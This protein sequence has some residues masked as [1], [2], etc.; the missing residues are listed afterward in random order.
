MIWAKQV[1]PN[2]HKKIARRLQSEQLEPRRLLAAQA[3][4][5]SDLATATIVAFGQPVADALTSSNDHDVHRIEIAETGR[6]LAQVTSDDANDLETHPMLTLFDATGRSLLAGESTPSETVI[7]VY[8]T[9][10]IYHL[11]VTPASGSNGGDY[12]FSP[13]FT[14]T[15]S[16]FDP[17]TLSGRDPHAIAAGD[18]NRDGSV[19]LAIA[20]RDPNRNNVSILTGLGDGS[21]SESTLD[22]DGEPTSV[23]IGDFTG[24]GL[25]D[26]VVSVSAGISSTNRLVLFAGQDNGSWQLADELPLSGEPAELA[27]GDFNNDGA[28]ELAVTLPSLEQLAL[29]AFDNQNSIFPLDAFD[30]PGIGDAIQAADVNDD[31]LMDLIV[32]DQDHNELEFFRQTPFRTFAPRT[33]TLPPVSNPLAR[34][35]GITTGDIDHDGDTD[36]VVAYA[37]IDTVTIVVGVNGDFVAGSTVELTSGATSTVAAE[38]SRNRIALE[39]MDQDSHLD[40]V[41]VRP[42]ASTGF[43]AIARGDGTGEFQ[44][45]DRYAISGNPRD[46]LVADVDG[47]QRPDVIT[48]GGFRGGVSVLLGL[49]DGHLR[50]DANPDVGDSPFDLVTADLNRDGQMDLVTA[51]SLSDGLS[52]LLGTGN[53]AVWS[54][55]DIDAANTTNGVVAADFNRDGRIDLAAANLVPDESSGTNSVSLLLARGDG[56]FQSTFPLPVEHGTDKLIATDINQDGAVD[57]VATNRTA[58]SQASLTVLLG[59]PNAGASTNLADSFTTELILPGVASPVAVAAA[60]VNGDGHLDLVSAGERGDVALYLSAGRPLVAP[61]DAAGPRIPNAELLRRIVGTASDLAVVDL[62]DDG[63]PELAVTDLD[64][65][66]LKIIDVIARE[67]TAAFAVGNG[68]SRVIAAELNQQ[69]GVDLAVSNGG[70]NDISLLHAD[71]TGHLTAGTTVPTNSNPQGLVSGDFNQDGLMDLATA[72][73]LDD[74]ITLL[75]GTGQGQFESADQRGDS[76][77]RAEPMF[78]DFNG[79]SVQDVAV[80]NLSGEILLRLGRAGE[81][82]VFDPPVVINTDRPTRAI[83]V[84]HQQGMDKLVAIDRAGS[85]TVIYELGNNGSVIGVAELESS[86]PR[87]AQLVTGDVTGDGLNDLV[88]ANIDGTVDLFSGRAMA[89]MDPNPRTFDCGVN[90]SSLS[91]IDANDDGRLDI[92]LTDQAAG[93]VTLLRNDGE[94]IFSVLEAQRVSSGRLLVDSSAEAFNSLQS[95]DVTADA[96]WGDYDNDSH[97]DMVAVHAGANNATLQLGQGDGSFVRMADTMIATGSRPI[98]V[99][100]GQLNDDTGDGVIDDQDHLDMVVLNKASADVGVWLGDGAGH[101]NLLTRIDGGNRPSGLTIHDADDDGLVDLVLGNEFGDI[102]VLKHNSLDD[103]AVGGDLFQTF[104]RAGRDVQLS[105]GDVDGGGI[106]DWI[107]INATADG[108]AFQ[109]GEEFAGDKSTLRPMAGVVAPTA[110]AMADLN[111]DGVQDLVVT[112]GGANN[113]LVYLGLPTA[114]DDEPRAAAATGDGAAPFADPLDFFAGTEPIDVQIYDINGDHRPDLVVTNRGSSDVSILLGNDL[115]ESDGEL[116]TPGVRVD[117]RIDGGQAASGLSSTLVGDFA[118]PNGE[119]AD[120]LPDLL[121]ADANS[122]TVAF[123]PGAPAASFDDSNLVLFPTAS[124]P[125]SLLAAGDGFI[126]INSGANS[127]SYF[128]NLSSPLAT[129]IEVGVRPLSGLLIPTAGDAFDLLIANNGDGSISIL[130]GDGQSLSLVDTFVSDDLRHPTA[131]AL[132]DLGAEADIAL[133]V[134]DEGDDLVRVFDRVDFNT[135]DPIV[136]LPPSSVGSV[137]VAAVF[138]TLTTLLL[139][140]PGD[141]ELENSQ[142]RS[143]DID[144]SATSPMLI[145]VGLLRA[146]NDLLAVGWSAIDAAMSEF[147]ELIPGDG[148]GD[149]IID[150]LRDAFDMLSPLSP[151]DILKS[152]RDVLEDPP[153]ARDETTDAT[154]AIPD[155]NPDQQRSDRKSVTSALAGNGATGEEANANAKD[156]APQLLEFE[157]LEFEPLELDPWERESVNYLSKSKSPSPGDHDE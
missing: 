93:T 54:I 92:A 15:S 88:L 20:V 141:V 3:I 148:V 69:P 14:P 145:V 86:A 35:T 61:V 59:N 81:S 134:A 26:L 32:A 151:W 108:I 90:V 49:G 19:D 53:T 98:T 78:A 73:N 157:L 79:D 84:L 46:L 105:V 131:L 72:N 24:D 67:V 18:F 80:T 147:H 126:S 12:L 87:T 150:A 149:E 65:N 57:L 135:A 106:D 55:A 143:S 89:G 16:P 146:L 155:P 91:L 30:V 142:Q 140:E 114:N 56:S 124:S 33:V 28:L 68:P 101:L 104:T 38:V 154:S 21:F 112:N 48:V 153:N 51:N 99:D 118:G 29:F 4:F 6:L 103:I 9:P 40:L 136:I 62:A 137:N 11:R 76:G 58:G 116:F 77:V 52:V 109:L 85:G 39:D 50:T 121:V 22:V 97:L 138:K 123:L 129:T 152:L 117:V 31:S 96:A 37:E 44:L 119:P 130:S 102:L 156:D 47:D 83:H 95:R 132:A 111:L 17:V 2:R 70:S 107:V 34:P 94:L 23:A 8:L 36:I 133:L 66:T 139:V 41:L 82:G 25:D 27:T 64:D 74:D 1:K 125:T 42:S 122:N 75:L 60:D 127:I 45:G 71:A 100:S 113:V 128:R 7:D 13:D 115:S 63:R 5:P 43:A 120:G 144:G 10:G 110:A